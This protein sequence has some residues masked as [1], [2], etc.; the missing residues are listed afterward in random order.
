MAWNGSACTG[1]STTTA[2]ASTQRPEA[3]R[4]EARRRQRLPS[5][6]DTASRRNAT[7][8]RGGS[9][10]GGGEDRKEVRKEEKRGSKEKRTVKEGFSSRIPR[11]RRPD[12]KQRAGTTAS[13]QK[14]PVCSRFQFCFCGV[15][16]TRRPTPT[17]AAS[18]PGILYIFGT[19]QSQKSWLSTLFST[20]HFFTKF[21]DNPLRTHPLNQGLFSQI[22]IPIKI[23]ILIIFGKETP[24]DHRLFIEQSYYRNK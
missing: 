3:R 21:L 24:V 2:R 4:T 17:S 6:S 5:R 20:P 1:A 18:R 12:E 9:V 16:G 8:A 22:G 15:C 23:L 14:Q 10:A 19:S 11:R 13:T 7:T